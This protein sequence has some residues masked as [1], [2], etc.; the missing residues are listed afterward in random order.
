VRGLLDP[1]A[2][3]PE[4]EQVAV[5]TLGYLLSPV[6]LVIPLMVSAVLAADAFAG[7]K[8]RRTLEG[9]LHLPVADRDLFLAKVLVGFVPAV[10]ITWVG[11]VI[12]AVLS[13]IM[14]WP[15]VQR[16]FLPF[17]QWTL[18][19]VWVAP[20]LALLALGLLVIVSSRAKTTQ[21]ANQL[22]GAVILPLIFLAASQTSALLLAP[23]WGVLLF[24]ALT[25]G[26]GIALV[27]VNAR[28]FTRDRLA[29]SS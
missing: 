15:L 29:A 23:V 21:E 13:N 11:A 3:L 12:F 24:G 25:W 14:A 20:A 27:L 5:L 26:G 28:R 18:V 8:E 2:S 7:E 6:L 9:L 19:I 10:I 4:R 22:G 16:P 17:A 1:I